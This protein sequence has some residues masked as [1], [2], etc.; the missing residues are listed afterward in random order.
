MTDFS[1]A[2]VVLVERVDE[3]L[4]LGHREFAHTQ[5]ARARRDLI[6]ERAADASG[7]EGDAAVVELVQAL[8]VE[9][10]ALRG[11]WTQVAGDIRE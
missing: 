11:L 1:K 10:V 7:R 2:R 6:A 4:D 8:E 5:Q 9:E 3:V